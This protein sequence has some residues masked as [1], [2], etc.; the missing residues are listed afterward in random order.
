MAHLFGRVGRVE[1]YDGAPVLAVPP[2]VGGPAKTQTPNTARK[3]T[4][5]GYLLVPLFGDVRD[6]GRVGILAITDLY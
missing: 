3:H 6:D 2:M 1:T 5:F 4:L